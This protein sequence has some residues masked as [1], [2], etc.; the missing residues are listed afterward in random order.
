M[1]DSIDTW[2]SRLGDVS[3]SYIKK[4]QSLGLITKIN[5]SCL[6]KREIC[7]ETKLTKKTC[8]C[9]QR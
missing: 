7:A 4:M 5:Y 1:L 8:A 3:I 2:H 6:N 9:I